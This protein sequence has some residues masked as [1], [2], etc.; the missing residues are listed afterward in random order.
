M[1]AEE[2]KRL[3]K[4]ELHCHLDGSLSK[5]FIQTHLGRDVSE[6]ELS[7]SA[8]CKSLVEYLEKFELPCACL[9]DEEGLEGAGYD[10]LKTMSAEEVCYAEIRFAP[11]FS[12]TEKMGTKQVLEALLRGLERGKKAFGIE[13]NVIT[14]AMRHHSEEENFKMIRD[15]REFLGA[16]VCAADLAG[17]EAQ[18]PMTEFMELFQK[19]KALGMPFTIHA[20]ECGSAQNIADAVK[21]GAGRIG[22][23]IAMRGHPGLQKLVRAEGIGIEMC[24]ISNLQTKAVSC[25]EE[26]PLR[27]FLKAGLSVSINTDNRTVSN[28][29]MTKELEFIQN[30]YGMND[31]DLIRLMKNAAD[32]AFASD[33]TKQKLYRKITEFEQNNR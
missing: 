27:E 30:T 1:R 26:Y 11:L 15:A 20:G 8:D 6:E 12:V 3:P 5:E 23:G 22:H 28:T 21:A 14:C 16:G 10:V 7:V 19:T 32:T 2:L 31:I 25:P 24:P 9:K 4:I 29:S 33:D 18:Y 13:Y 17:A